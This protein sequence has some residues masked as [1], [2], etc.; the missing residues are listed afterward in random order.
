MGLTDDGGLVCYAVGRASRA[1]DLADVAGLVD[2]TALVG[3]DYRP[4][5][6]VLYALG[7]AGGV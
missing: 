3:M 1:R 7:D 4:A 6:G 2:D 5:N